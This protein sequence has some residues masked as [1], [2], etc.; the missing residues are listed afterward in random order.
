MRRLNSCVHH[1][2]SLGFSFAE[3]F[4]SSATTSRSKAINASDQ[5]A[6]ES[7]RDFARA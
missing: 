4:F 1:S 7:P 5:A 3:S 6:G 2:A